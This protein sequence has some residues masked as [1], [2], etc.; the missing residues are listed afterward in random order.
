MAM[1][2]KVYSQLVYIDNSAANSTSFRVQNPTLPTSPE[3][4]VSR[5]R[6]KIPH[7][8]LGGMAHHCSFTLL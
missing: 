4:G 1:P 3:H 7:E 5:A 6:A 2:T 8:R